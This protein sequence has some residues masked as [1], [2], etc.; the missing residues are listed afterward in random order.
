MKHATIDLMQELEQLVARLEGGDLPLD[1]LL[2][3]YQRGAGLLKYCRE[4]LEAVES[5]IKVLDAE[6][7]AIEAIS[8]DRY[9][10]ASPAWRSI[11]QPSWVRRCASGR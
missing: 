11:G 3:G 4:Q 6:S 5:Q 7:G 2:S 8:S 1:Q 10:S 9:N